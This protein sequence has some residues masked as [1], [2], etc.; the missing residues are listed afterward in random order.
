V[1]RNRDVSSTGSGEWRAVP[2]DF[3]CAESW[4]RC[5][6]ALIVQRRQE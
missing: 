2:H 4:R 3:E 1:S 6:V 5:P